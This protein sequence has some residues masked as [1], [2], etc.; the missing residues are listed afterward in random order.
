V[1]TLVGVPASTF[2]S[3]RFDSYP[4]NDFYKAK[5]EY[6]RNLPGFM[7]ARLSIVAAATRSKQDDPLIAPTTLA[8]A[9]ATING[10]SAA[11]AWNTTAALTRQRAGAEIETR[12]AQ[13]NL[14]INPSPTVAV[15]ATWRHYETDN[16][17]AFIACNPLTGQIGRLINDGSG[18]AFVS[19]PAY[20]AVRCDLAAVRAL[21]IAPSAGN[22]NIRSVPFEYRQD[23]Y[24]LSADWRPGTKSNLTA[25]LEREIYHRRHRERDETREDKLKLGYTNRGFESLTMLFSYEVARRRGSEY[26]ADPYGEFLSASLG[27]LPT[28]IGTDYASWIHVMDT[29]QKYDLADRDSRSLNGRLNWAVADSVDVGLQGIWRDQRYPA[30]AFGR[31]GAN[32]LSSANLDVNWQASAEFALHGYYTWQDQKAHQTGLQANACVVG[33]TYYFFSDGSVSTSAVAPAGATLVGSTQVAPGNAGLSAC[34]TPGPLSPL[35][36]T[37]RSWEQ[38]QYS[39]N[40]TAGVGLRRGFGKA[41]L[42]L[43]YSYTMGRTSADYAYNAAALGLSPA[44]VALI[45]TGMPESRF[46]Q[47]TL[48]A[49]LGYPLTRATAV[50]V[51]YRYE[52]GKIS[53]WHYD[54]VQGNPVPAGNAVYLDYGPRNYNA[55]TI[56]L[57]LRMDL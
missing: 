46:G 22:V 19:T 8:L 47:N 33:N 28:A 45:G 15:R 30:S 54:G 31:N 14:A 5:A 56:G 9:G 21:D 25:A 11:N 23:N 57:F 12:L 20:L 24:I 55:N 3:A 13:A 34:Q 1:N 37:S 40:H 6:A 29:F 53:D 17:T 2:T 39:R 42:D 32:R 35:Y 36:P 16:S 43:S 44:Q 10:V 26:H 27:P 7:N 18:G 4:D 52:R 50:R 49:S 51:Y 38:I 48:E 41:K